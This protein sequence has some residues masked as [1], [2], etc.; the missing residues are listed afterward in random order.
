MLTQH[1]N[2]QAKVLDARPMS[3]QSPKTMCRRPKAPWRYVAHFIH[4]ARI[5]ISLPFSFYNLLISFP[6]FAPGLCLKSVVLDLFP[7]S[8]LLLSPCRWTSRRHTTPYQS[9]K[10]EPDTQKNETRTAF[11]ASPTTRSWATPDYRIDQLM[12]LA[13]HPR[14]MLITESVLRTPYHK[15]RSSIQCCSQQS[16]TGVVGAEHLNR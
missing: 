8:I 3:D 2:T 16:C 6:L 12:M 7:S 15:C 1:L 4:P 9:P 13:N 10:T 14:T 5:I 11:Y